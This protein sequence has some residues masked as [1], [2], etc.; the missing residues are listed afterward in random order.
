M[1][2]ATGIYKEEK[3]CISG[4]LEA[5]RDLSNTIETFREDH[6]GQAASIENTAQETFLNQYMVGCSV[7]LPSRIEKTKPR[8]AKKKVTNISFSS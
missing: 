1:E 4:I 7:I 8:T 2:L 5:A 3:E 6:S